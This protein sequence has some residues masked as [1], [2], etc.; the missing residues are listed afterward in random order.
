MPKNYLSRR[1]MMKR[2]KTLCF[3]AAAITLALAPIST[4][5]TQPQTVY[6]SAVTEQGCRSL[7]K[8]WYRCP[9]GD[10]FDNE[11]VA[12]KKSIWSSWLSWLFDSI[13]GTVRKWF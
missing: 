13:W 7:G 11:Y 2:T 8:G 10:V 1:V 6:A 3:L 9:N 12:P 4:S 5:Q